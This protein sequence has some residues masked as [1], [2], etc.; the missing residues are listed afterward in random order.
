METVH[1]C[2][3]VTILGTEYKVDKCCMLIGTVQTPSGTTPQFGLLHDIV[4]YGKEPNILFIFIL[5][6]TVKIF[7]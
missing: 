4:L 3:R 2:R 1:R 5:M 7:F 6:K